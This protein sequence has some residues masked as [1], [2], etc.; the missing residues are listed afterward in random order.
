[1]DFTVKQ[2][3]RTSIV[4]T[5]VEKLNAANASDLISIIALQD[6][7]MAT[8]GNYRNFYMRDSVRISHTINPATG[9]PV[10]HTLLSATVLADNC[11]T[12]D[13][14][15]TAMM[16]M[17]KDEA[18]ILDEKLEEI[19]VFLIYDDGMGGFKTFASENLKPFLSFPQ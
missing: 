14:Y 16:V 9:Y 10:D 2:I 3:E 7:A 15:A 1:M 18:I 4:A 8:S 11:M 17:G 12:A 6:R 5:N 13:A 19:E